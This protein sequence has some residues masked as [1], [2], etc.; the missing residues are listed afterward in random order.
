MANKSSRRHSK[1]AGPISRNRR[2]LGVFGLIIMLVVSSV[3]A[4]RRGSLGAANATSAEPPA[5]F[6]TALP[7][8][9]EYVYAGSKLIATE[10]PSCTFSISPLC[11]THP[12]SGGSATIFLTAGAGCPW[13]ASTP[14]SW[15][16]F[17]SDTSG[18]GNGLVSYELRENFNASGRAGAITIAGLTFPI[19]QA[20]TVTC[21]YILNP[22]K[23]NYGAA[24]GSGSIAVT[25]SD[26]GCV[27]QPVAN[28]PWV[29]ITAGACG[30]MGVG[31]VNYTVDV[32]TTGVG[33]NATIT[34]GGLSFAIKQTTA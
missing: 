8:A 6:Q 27:W 1:L 32:N 14:D 24:G 3:V 31:T 26:A 23:A 16:V 25:P 34:I 33:R 15:I 7:L 2:T 20:G 18:V 13:T 30:V 22:T 28:A 9:K 10:E 11:K 21:T 19:L 17:S 29:H 4:A 12:S 5:P